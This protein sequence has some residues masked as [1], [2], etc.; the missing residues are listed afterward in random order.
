[1]AATQPLPSKA[2]LVRR[3]KI[4]LRTGSREGHRGGTEGIGQVLVEG[5]F[6]PAGPELRAVRPPSCQEGRAGIHTIMR[7]SSRLFIEPA[8]D[9]MT[10]RNNPSLLSQAIRV[11]QHLTVNARFGARRKASNQQVARM[12]AAKSVD[13][14]GAR[15]TPIPDIAAPE[16]LHAGAKHSDGSHI[17]RIWQ[18]S[19]RSITP[20]LSYSQGD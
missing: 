7:K 18:S 9:V 5:A 3:R 11:G 1:M 8:I 16:W 6:E 15:G 13:H 20:P 12:S 4:S 19:G 2:A 10:R 17:G 14:Q